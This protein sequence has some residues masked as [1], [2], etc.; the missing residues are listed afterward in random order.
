M[1]GPSND[2]VDAYHPASE[3]SALTIATTRS[4]STGAN[5]QTLTPSGLRG[6]SVPDATSIRHTR[7]HPTGRSLE[8]TSGPFVDKGLPELSD[9]VSPPGSAMSTSGTPS[10]DHA[11]NSGTPSHVT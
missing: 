11:T 9:A 7:R 1:V 5:S 2:S 4:P 10:R 8:R 3:G 6:S